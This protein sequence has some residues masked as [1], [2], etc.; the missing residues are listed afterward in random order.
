[1]GNVSGS[2]R[3]LAMF[4]NT[5]VILAEF[6]DYNP[7]EHS[8]AFVSEFRFHPEQD[9][10]M[11]IA[12]LQKYITCRFSFWSQIIEHFFFAKWWMHI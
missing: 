3:V 7:N 12:I 1:M 4:S 10:E 9:E 5:Y 11:E 2:I 8:A 6:G